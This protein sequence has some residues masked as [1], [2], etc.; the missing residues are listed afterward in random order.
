LPRNLL[1]SLLLLA[2]AQQTGLLN[3]LVMA[4]VSL[5]DPTIPG[6]SRPIRTVVA[7]LLLT[8]LF[9]LVGGL[10]RTWNLRSYTGTM[11]PS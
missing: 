1:G 8:L 4:I 10:A 9:L 5:A 3:T 2:A 6:L 7:R 11:L